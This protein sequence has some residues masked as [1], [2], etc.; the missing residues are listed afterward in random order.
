M[1]LQEGN[2][3]AHNVLG[4]CYYRLGEFGG[5][6][7][8]WELSLMISPENNAASR[9]LDDL[10]GEDLASCIQ[11]YNEALAQAQKGRLRQAEK[12]LK[13]K[14][15][16]CFSFA[17]FGNLL[18]LC[19][20]GRSR[21]K[22]ALQTWLRVLAIDRENPLTLKYLQQGFAGDGKLGMMGGNPRG[23]LALLGGHKRP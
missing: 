12:I 6:R 5:A 14:K 3:Q 21:R 11:N 19:F 16:A 15:Q 20:Y 4:L 10:H 1:L 8:S 9:Y 23:L 13:Q 22:Q 18:G 2:V 7:E 17:S